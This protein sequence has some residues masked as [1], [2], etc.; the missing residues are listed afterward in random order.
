[1]EEKEA[2]RGW[3]G[4]G[5]LRVKPVIETKLS[6]GVPKNIA[7]EKLAGFV[8]DVQARIV[9][10]KGDHVELEISSEKVGKNRRTGDRSMAFRVELDFAEHRRER[11]N[12][13]GLAKGS[14]LETVIS[15]SIRPKRGRNR[16][17]VETAD[18]AR[19]VLQSLKGYLMAKE[20]HE[21]A[22][23]EPALA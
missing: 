19:L 13:V 12:G 14:Y 2:K 9:S 18:R 22:P 20:A 16:R 15:V 10:N 5:S 23:G 7:V 4:L 8:T 11:T 1:M 17:Q 3:W 21:E 6:T